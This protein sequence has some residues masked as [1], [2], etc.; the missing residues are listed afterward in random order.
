[1]R[2]TSTNVRAL[3]CICIKARRGMCVLCNL[4][5]CGH[6][7]LLSRY[8]QAIPPAFVTYLIGC[9]R[10]FGLHFLFST[11]RKVISASANVA[12]HELSAVFPSCALHPQMAGR[13]CSFVSRHGVACVCYATCTHA[14]MSNCYIAAVKRSY[15]HLL[16]ISVCVSFA[17]GST[18]S[19]SLV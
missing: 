10:L 2:V 19:K 4:Y 15:L 6:V 1:M 5:P 12:E 7:Q 18:S 17:L 9:E 16:H 14:D 8:G 11:F 13:S 3:L